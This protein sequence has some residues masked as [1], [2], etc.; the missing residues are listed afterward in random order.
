MTKTKP[1][2]AARSTKK[3]PKEPKESKKAP[4]KDE[5]KQEPGKKNGHAPKEKPPEPAKPAQQPEGAGPNTTVIDPTAGYPHPALASPEKT[6]ELKV[7]DEQ[8]FKAL[9]DE[10]PKPKGKAA[11]DAENKPRVAPTPF[12][13]S[14]SQIESMGLNWDLAIAHAVKMMANLGLPFDKENLQALRKR[15]AGSKWPSFF[16]KPL[17]A[18]IDVL[19][20]DEDLLKAHAA[21]YQ[22]EE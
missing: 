4:E 2:K 14:R 16:T 22:T 3:A 21:Q 17:I 5:P 6:K 18:A 12:S 8:L 13:A 10:A 1:A 19:I 7:S 20:G 11:K 15:V 9:I